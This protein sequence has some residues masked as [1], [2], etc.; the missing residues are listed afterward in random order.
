[1]FQE[2]RKVA[3]EDAQIVNRPNRMCTNFMRFARKNMQCEF[4]ERPWCG[5]EFL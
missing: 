4:F 5:R 1:M 3:L 2:V